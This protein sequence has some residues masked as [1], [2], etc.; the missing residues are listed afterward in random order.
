M[1]VSMFIRSSLE[2]LH[3]RRAGLRAK[4]RLKMV[5]SLTR[6]VMYSGNGLVAFFE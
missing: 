3:H 4:M 1:R 5:Y 2:V 6:L